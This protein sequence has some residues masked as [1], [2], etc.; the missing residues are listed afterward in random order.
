MTAPEATLGTAAALRDDR[1]AQVDLDA[2][3]PLLLETGFSR[4]Y[5]NER[6]RVSAEIVRRRP[7]SRR[8]TCARPA[9]VTAAWPTATRCSARLG[10]AVF[11]HRRPGRAAIQPRTV[12]RVAGLL[13]YVS[14][15]HAFKVGFQH[16]FGYRGSIATRQRRHQPAVSATAGRFA[17]QVLNTPI[18]TAQPVNHDLGMFIQDTW[19]TQRLTLSPGLRWDYFNSSIPAQRRPPAGSCRRA[20]FDG[21]REHPQLEQ[22][23]AADWRGLR[24]DRQRPDRRQGKLRPLR[25]IGRDRASPEP[26][27]RCCS[28]PTRAP[29]PT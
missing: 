4:T 28:R 7:A 8:S 6:L 13:A 16:R 10:R 22:R 3:Q 26:T 24:S 1:A 23:R 21:G 11:R 27:T 19:T 15:A 20:R 18:T 17:V 9:R 5:H 29:G 2:R 14:G 12:E 25:A